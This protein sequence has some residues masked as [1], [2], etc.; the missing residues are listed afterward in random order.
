MAD[1]ASTLLGVFEARQRREPVLV[2]PAYS[3]RVVVF[4]TALVMVEVA[5][6]RDVAGVA[7]KY[8]SLPLHVVAVPHAK[9]A[10]H[11]ARLV[12]RL[13]PE[14]GRVD[15]RWAQIAEFTPDR[16]AQ[17]F[18]RHVRGLDNQQIT[19]AVL[20]RLAIPELEL[21]YDSKKYRR[22]MQLWL[23]LP[24][25]EP[26]AGVSSLMSRA[27]GDR[28]REAAPAEAVWRT[29]RRP[30]PGAGRRWAERW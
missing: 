18:P 24:P 28:F 29:V 11:L 7:L 8:A 23:S 22:E 12:L 26:L 20:T 9:A 14:P 25:S 27:L 4:D 30:C 16:L 6:I 13:S 5:P 1:A 10:E 21:K 17:E 15:S 2:K 3:H 19:S